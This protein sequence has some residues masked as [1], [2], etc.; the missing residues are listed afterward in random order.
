[1]C[2]YVYLYIYIYIY[3]H[4]FFAEGPEIPL[5]VAIACFRCAHVATRSRETS[6]G[7]VEQGGA[8]ANPVTARKRHRYETHVFV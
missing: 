2:M 4:T 7:E 6:L 1:M 8:N 5:H 3:I